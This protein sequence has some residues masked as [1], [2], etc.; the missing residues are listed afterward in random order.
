MLI[1]D[2]ATA[3]PLPA[4]STKSPESLI[5][6]VTFGAKTNSWLIGARRCSI[7]PKICYLS[8]EERPKGI[9][10]FASMSLVAI[11][12]VDRRSLSFS[13]RRYCTWPELH[14][15][16]RSS[17]KSGWKGPALAAELPLQRPPAEQRNTRGSVGHFGCGP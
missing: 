17:P 16:R 1:H 8:H 4:A 6:P 7:A 2:W 5:P 15:S 10:A 14:F 13:T 12:V 3:Q 9:L 11:A